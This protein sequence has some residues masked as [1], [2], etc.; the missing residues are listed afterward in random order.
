[1][2]FCFGALLILGGLGILGYGLFIF[3]AWLPLLYAVLGFEIGLLLGKW[4]SGDVALLAIILG[5]VGAIAATSAAYFLEP[6]RRTILGS[7]GGALLTLSL[8]S[9]L[10]LDHLLNGIF[11]AILM[12]GGGLLGATV[13]S[14]YFDLLIVTASALGG[15]TL[16]VSGAQLLLPTNDAG[17]STLPALATAI[18]T[19]LGIRWQISN[20]ASWIPVQPTMQDAVAN[21]IGDHSES[22]KR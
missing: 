3:Y 7:V 18:L 12:V 9:L 16:M 11:G 19:A 1:M 6:Y 10:N 22:R 5:I 17:W 8:A 2:L 20:L 14:K 15:A 4:L 21:S 13:V